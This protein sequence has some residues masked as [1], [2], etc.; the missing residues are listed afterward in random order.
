MKIPFDPLALAAAGKK[1]SP[2]TNVYNNFRRFL[3][4]AGI[5]HG[6]RGVGPRIYDF[7][8]TF[9]VHCLKRWSEQNYDLLVY[10]PILKTY[11]GHKSLRGTSYYLR[12]T[13]DVFPEITLK[14]EQR[15]PDLIPCLGGF[16]NETD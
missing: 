11:M 3:W 10:L 2:N 7:R 9:A 8:H 12:M 4:A 13:A 6:G 1:D 15:F 5:S 16:S 14:L